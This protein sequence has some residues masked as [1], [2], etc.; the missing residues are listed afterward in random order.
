[1]VTKPT[2]TDLNWRVN[3]SMTRTE[4]KA[5]ARLGSFIGNIEKMVKEDFK[6]E[7]AIDWGSVRET[8]HM[9]SRLV[10]ESDDFRDSMVTVLT[11][12]QGKK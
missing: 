10:R 11:D 6:S 9:F 5:I 4:V 12:M 8:F 1:M 7:K 2:I 3:V